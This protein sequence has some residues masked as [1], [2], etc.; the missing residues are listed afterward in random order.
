MM[1]F[2]RLVRWRRSGK[3][4]TK[5]LKTAVAQNLSTGFEMTALKHPTA[6][7]SSVTIAGYLLE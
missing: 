2:S 1:L 4:L 7:L 5:R 3:P 6:P